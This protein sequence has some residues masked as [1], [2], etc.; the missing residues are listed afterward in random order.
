MACP[1]HVPTYRLQKHGLRLQVI[2][3]EAQNV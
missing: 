3:T 2:S 1:L